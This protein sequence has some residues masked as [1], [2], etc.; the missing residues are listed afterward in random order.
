MA[1]TKSSSHPVSRKPAVPRRKTAGQTNASRGRGSRSQSKP[2]TRKSA[3]AKAKSLKAARPVPGNARDEVPPAT[4][5]EP[6]TDP[7]SMEWGRQ[8]L[9]AELKRTREEL[10]HLRAAMYS[11]VDIDPEEGDVEVSERLKNV[12]LIAMLEKRETAL[13]EALSS[14]LKGRYGICNRCQKPIGKGRLEARPD[15]KFCVQCQEEIERAAR[16]LA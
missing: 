1:E 12:T 15:A 9:D 7:I 8:K 13:Q 6:D 14:L 4:L 3:A 10:A 2:T 5:P 11:E 16:R